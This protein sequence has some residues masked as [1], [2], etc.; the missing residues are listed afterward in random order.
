[1]TMSSR[2]FGIDSLG[3]HLCTC[4]VH[5]GAKKAHDWEVDQLPDLFRTTHKVK[6]QHVVKRRGHHCGDIELAGYVAN[7]TGPV[8][9]VLD[10]RIVHDCF[11]SSSDPNLNGKLHWPN[12]IDKSLNET[13]TDKI[14]KYRT[15]YNDNP[16]TATAFMPDIAS[17]SGRLQSDFDRILFLQTH[18]ETDRFLKVSGV[19]S[20][21]S[22]MGSFFHFRHAAFSSMMNSRVSSILA[23]AAALRI[24]LD[25]DGAPI[26]SKSHTHPSH[27]QT[28]RLLTSFLSLGVP[29]PRPTQCIRGA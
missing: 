2:K 8:P 24:T 17:T 11:G 6:T 23:K 14:R 7:V 15:D 22:N 3:D 21:Q 20:A 16:P 18:R 28:S 19:Q 10:L 4:T 5:S 13:N 26:T 29:V 1:M 12:D 9:L 27:S 25:L